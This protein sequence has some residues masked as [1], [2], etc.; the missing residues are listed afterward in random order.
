VGAADAEAQMLKPVVKQFKPNNG[1]DPPPDMP[2]RQTLLL[3]CGHFVRR[4]PGRGLHVAVHCELCEFFFAQREGKQK[5]R[6]EKKRHRAMKRETKR[7]RQQLR[8]QRRENPTMATAAKKK[9]APAKVVAK[10]DL[11][12]KGAAPKKEKAPRVKA[13][14]KLILVAK[15]LYAPKGSLLAKVLKAFEAA[16]ERTIGENVLVIAMEKTGIKVE[17]TKTVK[18]LV[19]GLLRNLLRA[20]VVVKQRE[21]KHNP[22]L[23]AFLEGEDEDPNEEQ[24]DPTDDVQDDDEDE[25]G[26]D[27]DAEDEGGDDD[28]EEDGDEDGEDEEED[29]DDEDEEAAPVAKKAPAKKTVAKPSAKKAPAAKKTAKKTASKK[30]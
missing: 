2:L 21:V 14:R 4:K 19:K 9:I 7:I 27:D 10:K 1:L 12:K 17:G 6:E 25:E 11:K 18:K 29:G 13:G 30:R 20:G 26:E 15:H 23:S 3:K 28:S 22:E 5:R 16:D 8:Q 24:G